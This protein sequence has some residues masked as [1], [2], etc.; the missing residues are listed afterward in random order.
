[1]KPTAGQTMTGGGVGVLVLMA[2]QDPA[3]SVVYA[4]LIMALLIV[5]RISDVFKHK[6]N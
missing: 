4:S 6:D 5:Y 3:H 1:M 2:Q